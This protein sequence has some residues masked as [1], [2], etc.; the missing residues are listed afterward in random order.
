MS[1]K[2]K[3]VENFRFCSK[4]HLKT[5]TTFRK[6]ITILSIIG[7]CIIGVCYILWLYQYRDLDQLV[8]ILKQYKIKDYLR[9]TD[10]KIGSYLFKMDENNLRND[11]RSVKWISKF[12]MISLCDKYDDIFSTMTN[13]KLIQ[14]L[15]RFSNITNGDIIYLSKWQLYYF[16]DH[17]LPNITS[18]FT[19]IMIYSSFVTFP[20]QFKMD[21]IK[22]LI[23]N[24]YL[25]HI[26]A[27]N[28]VSIYD[29]T[30][31]MNMINL[32]DSKISSIPM[33]ILYFD[34]IHYPI[35]SYIKFGHSDSILSHNDNINKLRQDP[36][37]ILPLNE[38]KLKI[39]VDF[40][41]TDYEPLNKSQN[42]NLHKIYQENKVNGIK[43]RNVIR[44]DAFHKIKIKADIF[45]FGKA[46]LNQYDLFIERSKFVF[47]FAPLG[48]GL[49][50]YRMWE[51]LIFGNI[52]IVETSPL[53]K[54]YKQ[55]PQLPVVIVNKYEDITSAMLLKWYNKYKS[56]SSLINKDTEYALT[57]KYHF[58]YIRSK[59]Q[60]LV[61]QKTEP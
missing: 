22:Q 36:T 32:F 59:S 25:L 31:D 52:N 61:Q 8:D 49:D 29:D 18:Y 58:N 19:I 40:V 2:T 17:I 14:N 35:G 46:R 6:R 37:K 39:Y 47:L 21:K 28:G 38:R 23:T 7:M 3:K 10:N 51:G 57:N 53:D 33:G 44:S 13:N 30:M 34:N 43:R 1:P 9:K 55:H 54:L 56:Y 24:K 5:M 16:I 27:K 48:Q 60:Q 26:W 45:E 42:I 12:G 15:S 11:S 50:T 4:L 20:V 41:L